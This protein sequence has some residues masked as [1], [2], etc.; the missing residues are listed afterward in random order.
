MEELSA[1]LQAVVD[2]NPL[3][4]QF[5]NSSIASLN[6]H[7]ERALLE[8]FA[9]ARSRGMSTAMLAECYNTIVT[10][11]RTEQAFFWKH[12]RYRFA[13]YADVAEHVY[14]DPAY[15]NRYMYGLALTSFLWPNHAAI[16]DFFERT[17][18]PNRSG[19][20]L[21]IGPG[22]GYFIRRAADLGAFDSLVGVDISPTSVAMTRDILAQA[23]IAGAVSI[24]EGDFL[25][26]DERDRDYSCIVMGE[27]LEHVEEPARFLEKIARISA[28]ETHIFVTTCVNAPAIDHIFLFRSP[29]E[30][31]RLLVES[32]LTIAD[33]LYVPYT[34]KTLEDCDRFALAVNV[35]YVLRR[36]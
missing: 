14:L 36:A 3:H 33:R 13:G 31:E 18:P 34:G 26:F 30:V 9:Y 23:G 19:N 4:A 28:P 10:D 24:V 20:Y 22:H 21:E 2:E 8:Y 7:Q 1:F 6:A 11:T 25:A 27:V 5:I 16:F 12:K 35:A 32:G 15:M 29:E 17:F